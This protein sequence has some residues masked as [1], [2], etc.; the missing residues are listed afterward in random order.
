MPWCKQTTRLDLINPSRGAA[1]SPLK[2]NVVSQF[3]ARQILLQFSRELAERLGTEV[4]VNDKLNVLLAE[5]RELRK[6]GLT[7]V[8][9]MERMDYLHPITLSRLKK[10]IDGRHLIVAESCQE[11]LNDGEK[12]AT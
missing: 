9:A 7:M 2:L 8:E 12:E 3:D 10:L 4:N 5:Y 6:D 11:E 1:R